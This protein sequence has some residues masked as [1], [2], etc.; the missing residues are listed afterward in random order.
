[1][2]DVDHVERSGQVAGAFLTARDCPAHLKALVLE[3]IALHHT[4]GADRS[5]E[6]ILMRDADSL[7]F[8]GV[9]GA[10]RDFSK[11]PR[12][13]RAAFVQVQK[14]REKVPALLHLEAAKAI[15]AQRVQETEKLLQELELESFGFF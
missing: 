6:A 3:C 1:M 8:L 10:V 15:G 2:K 5:L 7:D 13:L 12:N 14:R 4:A 9:V 11:N